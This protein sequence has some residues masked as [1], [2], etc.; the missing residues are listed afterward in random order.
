MCLPYLSLYFF[1]IVS[2][3]DE[4]TADTVTKDN[5]NLV[6][7]TCNQQISKEEI[8]RMR[9]DGVSGEGI[10]RVLFVPCLIY[11]AHC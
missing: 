11:L 3:K 4:E 9:H 6:G 5:R 10:Y 7:N 2:C 1:I 8:Q